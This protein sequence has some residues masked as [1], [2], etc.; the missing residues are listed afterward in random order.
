MAL[1]ANSQPA[2]TARHVS[3]AILNVLNPAEFPDERSCKSECSQH[4]G[5]QKNVQHK[6]LFKKSLLFLATKL[7]DSLSYRSR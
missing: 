5:E 3:E 7:W 2:P 6:K 4:H 1:Q